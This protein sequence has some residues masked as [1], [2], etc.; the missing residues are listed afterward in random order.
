MMW[1]CADFMVIISFLN[2]VLGEEDLYYLME[3][4]ASIRVFYA[5]EHIGKVLD[6]AIFS[7]KIAYCYLK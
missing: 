6:Q 7:N 5:Q 2:E 3:L 1:L 4:S